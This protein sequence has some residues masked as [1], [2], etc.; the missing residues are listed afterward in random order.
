MEA[1]AYAHGQAD[2]YRPSAMT[3]RGTLYDLIEVI[4]EEI[5][6]G[7]EHLI[8]PVVFDLI[9]SHKVKWVRSHRD[10]IVR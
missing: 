5:E 6:P 9:E 7:E 3:I 8:V 2:S 4:E 1:L 10:S